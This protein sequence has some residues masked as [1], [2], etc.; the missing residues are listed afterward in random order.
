MPLSRAD[1]SLVVAAYY[2]GR[3]PSDRDWFSNSD[4]IV[5]LS[6]F[7]TG[8]I[9]SEECVRR[10]SE[11]SYVGGLYHE[12]G[13]LTELVETRYRELIKLLRESPELIEGAGNLETPA[14]PTFTSCRLTAVGEKLAC[15]LIPSFREKPEFPNWP[16]RRTFPT[17]P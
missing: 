10:F 12:D 16:D 5:T 9:S 7:Y 11:R 14:D 2:R 13:E 3:I 1:E 15:L 17:V 8:E 4:Q 6:L